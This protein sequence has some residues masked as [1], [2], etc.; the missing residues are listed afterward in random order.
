MTARPDHQSAAETWRGSWINLYQY[1]G[2]QSHLG[3]IISATREE[4]DK[5]RAVWFEGVAERAKLGL[6]MAVWVPTREPYEI[7][8]K[9]E[10]RI[11]D[12]HPSVAKAKNCI[13]SIAIP[14]EV[15]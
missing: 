2:G 9:F 10:C 14:H 12:D 13:F 6:V 11:A 4:A 3:V 7:I 8:G 1:R 15:L 5:V